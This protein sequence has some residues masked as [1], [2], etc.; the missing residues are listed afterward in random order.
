MLFMD[1]ERD[2]LNSQGS[3]GFRGSLGPFGPRGKVGIKGEKGDVGLPGLPGDQVGFMCLQY[4]LSSAVTSPLWPQTRVPIAISTKQ[5]AIDLSKP[6][7]LIHRQLLFCKR[8]V[9]VSFRGRRGAR[10]LDLFWPPLIEVTVVLL[11]I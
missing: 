1:N 3:K 5:F 9:R 8:S 11:N 6:L 2:R 7:N 10:P 4:N